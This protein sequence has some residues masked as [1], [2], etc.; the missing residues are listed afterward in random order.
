MLAMAM[1]LKNYSHSLKSINLDRVILIALFIIAGLSCPSCTDRHDVHSYLESAWEK[2][3]Q[4]DYDEALE[5]LLKTERSFSDETPIEYREALERFRGVCY[6]HL[7][8][9]DKGKVSL[10]KAL[11]YSYQ[12]QDTTR[13]LENLHNLSLTCAYTD[14][15]LKYLERGIEISKETDNKYFLQLFLE[16]SIQCHIQEGNLEEADKRIRESYGLISENDPVRSSLFFDQCALWIKQD[17]ID[18]AIKGFNS[19]MLTDSITLDGQLSRAYYLYTCHYNLGDFKTALTY[20]D[21]IQI[22]QD[23]IRQIDGENRVVRIE[24]KFKSQVEREN[25]NFRLALA[26]GIIGCIIFAII[27]FFTIRELRI[28]RHRVNQEER[29]DQLNVELSRLQ[30][31]S[32][33]GS[34]DEEHD[35]GE[36][37]VPESEITSVLIEKFSL[38]LEVIRN[39]DQL[40]RL[41]KLN[42]LHSFSHEDKIELQKIRDIIIGCFSDCCFNM[43]ELYPAMTNDDCLYCT[44]SMCGCSK[45]VMSHLMGASD[46]ALRQRKSRIKQKLPERMFSF[47]FQ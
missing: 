44:M 32:E 13:I 9:L 21:S 7:K 29:I 33:E 23:S 3:E 25:M 22:F 14:E 10:Q 27:I 35:G 42:L 12:M 11:E 24:E 5:G 26:G 47:F 19:I 15:S 20:K 46:D 43:R 18:K 40:S 16:K 1:I 37:A 28:K 36:A 34:R 45:D 30:R 31:A 39:G 41:R 4:K 38:S 17:S 6:I 8:V 2:M